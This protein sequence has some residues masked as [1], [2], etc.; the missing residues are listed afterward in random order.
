MDRREMR[1]EVRNRLSGPGRGGELY[2]CAALLRGRHD[3][4]DEAR[5]LERAVRDEWTDRTR[6]FPVC[7]Q[8]G[9][10]RTSEHAQQQLCARRNQKLV[11]RA[12][13]L[14]ME[15]SVQR[16]LPSQVSA[17]HELRD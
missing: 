17:L 15:D 2:I 10:H 12:M 7:E 5:S 1:E 6:L 9:Q 8:E 16:E 13:P 4:H 14:A 3:T 11:I